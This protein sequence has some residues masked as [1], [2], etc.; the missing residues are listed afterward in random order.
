MTNAP[1][2]DLPADFKSD[3]LEWLDELDAP[4]L[5]VR[6]EAEQKLIEAGPAAF[7]FLPEEKAGLSIEAAERL[8]RVRSKLLAARVTEESSDITVRLTDVTNLAEALEAI[9]R[10]S[11]IEFEGGD[12]D[13]IAI[14]S[15]STPLPFWHAVD[16]VLDQA[17]L[18]INFYSGETGTLALVERAEDRPSRVD[19]AAYSGVYRIEP[20]AVSSRRVL[21]Q[22]DQSALN[23]SLEIAWEPRLTPIGLTIPIDQL[24]GTLDNGQPL[25]PQES[26][27]TVD[28]AANSDLAFS[29]FY[30]PMQLPADQPGK[31]ESLSGVIE[32]LLPGKTKD[33]ELALSDPGSENKIDSMTVKLEDVRKNGAIYEVR[34]GIV[35]ADADRSLE[36]HRQWIFQNKVFV[37]DE[38]GNR[39]EHLGYELYRQTEDSIG[40]AYLFDIGSLGKS[41]VIYQSPTSVIKNEVPFVLQD[42]PLP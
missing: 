23:I 5:S 24:S 19:S 14:Q 28:I 12:N 30:L 40:I 38:A 41:K 34:L 8:K 27:G 9:S 2:Q 33:F 4:S 3:V 39:S 26:G 11:G 21:N 1:G 31:I 7:E 15:V 32:S 6:K 35:L 22:P 13:T 18:D 42:I 37:M 20:T 29:E 17:D 25:K 16:L 10:D 36:S